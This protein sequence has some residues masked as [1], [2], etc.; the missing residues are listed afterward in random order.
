MVAREASGCCAAE[1]DE[2]GRVAVG[3]GGSVGGTTEFKVSDLSLLGSCAVPFF[4]FSEY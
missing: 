1:D 4:F 3:W 2:I